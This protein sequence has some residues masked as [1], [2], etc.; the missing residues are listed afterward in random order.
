MADPGSKPRSPATGSTLLKSADSLPLSFQA[1]DR[2]G[3]QAGRQ[4]SQPQVF[5]QIP[6][7]SVGCIPPWARPG[8]LLSEPP[9]HQEGECLEA[10]C[11]AGQVSMVVIPTPGGPQT[12]PRPSCL[13]R[14]GWGHAGWSPSSKQF[15]EVPPAGQLLPWRHFL[16]FSFPLEPRKA[17]PLP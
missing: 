17:N 4:G 1:K 8:C 6:R 16:S 13:H 9:V 5:F 7:V 15:G 12:W 10:S 14:V 3:F 2:G 11:P